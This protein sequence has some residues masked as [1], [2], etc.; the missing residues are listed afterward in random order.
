GLQLAGIGCDDFGQV[1]AWTGRVDRTVVA[2]PVPVVEVVLRRAVE[3]LRIL[4][5]LALPHV[6]ALAGLD[7][8]DPLAQERVLARVDREPRPVPGGIDAVDAAGAGLHDTAG[9]L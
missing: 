7:H 4:D 5:G 9:R 2:V 6:E 8:D 1:L 3:G